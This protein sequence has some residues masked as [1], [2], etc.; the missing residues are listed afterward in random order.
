MYKDNVYLQIRDR[1]KMVDCLEAERYADRTWIVA[2][3]PRE[4]CSSLVV[5]LEGYRGGFDV[6]KLKRIGA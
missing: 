5:K 1:A 6:T 2:S 3:N 4:V